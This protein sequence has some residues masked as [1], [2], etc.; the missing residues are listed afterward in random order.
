MFRAN[1]AGNRHFICSRHFAVLQL[2][3]GWKCHRGKFHMH[4]KTSVFSPPGRNLGDKHLWAIAKTCSRGGGWK[5]YENALVILLNNII[6]LYRILIVCR[7]A[8]VPVWVHTYMH[9]IVVIDYRISQVLITYIQAKPLHHVFMDVSPG[10]NSR[11]F[12]L[13]WL[14]TLL[15]GCY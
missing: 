13:C 4:S 10:N 14:I 6:F 9:S 8:N 12:I 7:H 11:K 1:W 3:I 2:E 15:M 5:G